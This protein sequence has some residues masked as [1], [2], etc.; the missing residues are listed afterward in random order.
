MR[1]TLSFLHGHTQSPQQMQ[2]YLEMAR[3]FDGS[4]LRVGL[5][6]NEA[7]ITAFDPPV[8]ELGKKA[9]GKNYADRSYFS[10]I[11]REPRTTLSNIEMARIGIPR[12]RLSIISP[13]AKNGILNHFI[14][15]VL[16]LKQIEKIFI[17]VAAENSLFYTLLDKNKNIIFTNHLDQKVM[18]SFKRIG[19]T[20]DSE[21]KIIKHW[22]PIVNDNTPI[23][24]RWKNSL[25]IFE[26]PIGVTSE[27]T[28]ILEQPVA[29]YQKML[30]AK[31]TDKLM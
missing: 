1:P 24:E 6:N 17:K 31:Y 7:T 28:L 4:L 26:S 13:V 9:I 14:L 25:Y 5:L 27:W 8:D 18:S 21:D 16:D 22:S 12:P 10:L 19:G 29:P 11:K 20:M 30:Y 15:G 2:P 23:S 3:N